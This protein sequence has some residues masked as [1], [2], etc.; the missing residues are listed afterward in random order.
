MENKALLK[1]LKYILLGILVA[2]G[3][4][5]VSGFAG[6]LFNG[7]DVGSASVFGCCLYLCVVI[8]T[9]TGLILSKMD[10]KTPP[11][12]SDEENKA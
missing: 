8:V 7:M 9:C 12:N 2:V 1:M 6:E 10:Q 5:Y 4:V 3:G 11:D